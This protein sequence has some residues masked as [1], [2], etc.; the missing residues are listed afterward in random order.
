MM[1]EIK[2]LSSGQ[3]V[4][5]TWNMRIDEARERG[6]FTYDDKSLA[7][8]WKSCKI[9]ERYNGRD[10]DTYINELDIRLFHLGIRFTDAVC[11]DS[12]NL[13]EEIAQEIDEWMK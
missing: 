13:A 5:K 10:I 12:F 6:H 9:G 1:S 11:R 4:R 2:V 8:E 3:R 7:R